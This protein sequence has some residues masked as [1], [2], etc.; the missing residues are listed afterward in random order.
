MSLP[1]I[2]ASTTSQTLWNR[3]IKALDSIVSIIGK[4]EKIV[5]VVAA[6]KELLRAIW[7]RVSPNAQAAMVQKVEEAALRAKPKAQTFVVV[8]LSIASFLSLSFV[9]ILG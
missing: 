3:V 4:F 5:E 6:D 2:E 8:S 1:Q 9:L 7:L